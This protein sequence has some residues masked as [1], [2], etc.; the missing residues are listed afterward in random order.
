MPEPL[1]PHYASMDP[2]RPTQAQLELLA[3]YGNL[4]FGRS[5]PDVYMSEAQ[6][7]FDRCIARQEQYRTEVAAV[8]KRLQPAYQ[9]AEI[10]KLAQSLAGFAQGAQMSLDAIKEERAKLA[11][12]VELKPREADSAAA[13]MDEIDRRQAL[14]A[15]DA[16]KRLE[17]YVSSVTEAD[18]ATFFAFERAPR[19]MGL[20]EGFSPQ[21]IEQT[22]QAWMELR[23]PA[24]T[25]RLRNITAA[26]DACQK[27]INALKAEAKS[28][29]GAPA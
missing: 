14:R 11:E 29:G 9:G 15:L 7:L 12:A 2:S 16:G 3:V 25:E 18:E 22:R 24:A 27:A 4:N 20:K 19:W 1:I 10:S 26:I 6:D 21:I 23:A 8:K 28:N 5:S 13:K 17:I